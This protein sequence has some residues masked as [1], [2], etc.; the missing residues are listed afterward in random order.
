MAN[1]NIGFQYQIQKFTFDATCGNGNG[2]WYQINFVT[3]YFLSWTID[4]T[5]F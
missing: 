2:V 1:L 3:K 4:V 5:Y